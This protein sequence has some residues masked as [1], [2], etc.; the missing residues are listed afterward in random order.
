MLNINRQMRLSVLGP[1]GSGKST[2]ARRISEVCGLAHIYPGELLRLEAQSDSPLA[3][4]IREYLDAGQL[5]PSDI[6]FYLVEREITHS[7]DRFVLDGFPR[8]MT[9]VLELEFL[10]SKRNAKL[11]ALILLEVSRNEIMRRLLARGRPDDTPDIIE[12]RIDIFRR[13][14]DAV[15]QFYRQ[16]GI[17]SVV[18]GE[19]T[20]DSVTRR[21]LSALGIESA[22]P[23][24]HVK[25]T[26]NTKHISP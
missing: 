8:T 22:P 19:G 15:I 7:F 13:E 9:Q 21:I 14:T 24:I 16:A 10:L 4:R 26:K 2:Q 18:D 1:P 25:E 12:R 17:L 23:I 20:P 6:V 3:R 5:V 11:N